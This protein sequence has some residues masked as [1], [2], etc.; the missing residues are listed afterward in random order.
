MDQKDSKRRPPLTPTPPKWNSPLWYLPLMLLALWF[1]QSMVVQFA[2]KT[3]PYSEFKEHLRNGEI[4]E[5]AVKEST[6]EGTIRPR[7]ETAARETSTNASG[8]ANLS[9]NS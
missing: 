4:K 2:Y 7:V 1:W 8:V 3:I 6:I 9:T 5:C